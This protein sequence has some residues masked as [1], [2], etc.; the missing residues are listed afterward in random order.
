[1]NAK[2]PLVP[3]QIEC[4]KGLGKLTD[5]ACAKR[6]RVAEGLDA[7]DSAI[8]QS[9]CGRGCDIGRAR[10]DASLHLIG[11]PE[12]TPAQ[13]AKERERQPTDDPTISYKRPVRKAY[14]TGRG[15]N[16]NRSCH[17]CKEMMINVHF[18][19][20]YCDKCNEGNK[21]S[22]KARPAVVAPAPAEIVSALGVDL[23]VRPVEATTEWL[24][25]RDSLISALDAELK[26]LS[27]RAMEI[28]NA[29]CRLLGRTTLEY[30]GLIG[31]CYSEMEQIDRAYKLDV[32]AQ[33][34]PLEEWFRR[35]IIERATIVLYE[36]DRQKRAKK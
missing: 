11:L 28:M 4:A 17:R 34:E 35:A 2:L 24:S 7:G 18:S 33:G 27:A 14:A 36:H 9:P 22:K 32:E 23:S 6:W 10:S 29:R 15:K 19:R 31:F 13:L 26:A 3:T 20:K 25:K 5:R 8:K 12:A 21:I 16:V 1:M 30:T